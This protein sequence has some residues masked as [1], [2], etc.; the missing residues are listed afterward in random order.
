MTIALTIDSISIN[1]MF[2]KALKV[3]KGINKATHTNIFLVNCVYYLIIYL[4][5]YNIPC[6]LSASNASFVKVGLVFNR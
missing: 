3:I 1:K 4:Y 6:P 5:S 2:I